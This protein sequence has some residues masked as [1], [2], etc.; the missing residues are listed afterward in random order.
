MTEATYSPTFTP[1][2]PEQI[3]AAFSELLIRRGG[4]LIPPKN[5][6]RCLEDF[7]NLRAA[8]HGNGDISYVASQEKTYYPGKWE[9]VIHLIVT[10]EAERLTGRGEFM[11]SPDSSV[12]KYRIKPSVWFTETFEGLGHQGLGRRRLITMNLAATAEF[13]YSL[14]SATLFC[15]PYE[16]NTWK[17]L[18]RDG[19]AKRYLQRDGAQQSPR[20]RFK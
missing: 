19:L 16:K 8:I 5:A 6:P 14:H 10:T 20:Y 4:L 1:I 3:P 18:V 17:H 7:T 11:F 15:D 2:E 9:R 13:G 12:D